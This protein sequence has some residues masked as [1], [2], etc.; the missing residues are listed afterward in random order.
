MY[1][2]V[3][4]G[5]VDTIRSI[6]GGNRQIGIAVDR[7]PLPSGALERTSGINAQCIPRA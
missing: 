6:P 3:Q 1:A 2:T 4:S 7:P 5:A